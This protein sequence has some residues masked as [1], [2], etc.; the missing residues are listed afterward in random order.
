MRRHSNRLRDGLLFV[1]GLYGVV[2]E[3]ESNGAERPFLLLVLVSMM[4]LPLG[5]GIDSFISRRKS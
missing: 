5:H 3:V 2:H 1:A 4:G